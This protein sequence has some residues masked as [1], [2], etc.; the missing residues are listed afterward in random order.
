MVAEIMRRAD[1]GTRWGWR[2]GLR[3]IPVLVAGGL[4]QQGFLGEGLLVLFILYGLVE[5]ILWL[6]RRGKIDA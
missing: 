4:W 5:G 3:L 6:T 1:S 2:A